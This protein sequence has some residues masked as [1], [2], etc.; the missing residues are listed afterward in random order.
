MQTV[1][2]GPNAR[3]EPDLAAEALIPE[4]R[5][6]Q[7]RRHRRELLI[8]LVLALAGLAFYGAFGRPSG[9]THVSDQTGGPSSAGLSQ[10]HVSHPAPEGVPFP[11]GQGFQIGAPDPEAAITRALGALSP[12]PYV[13]DR[14]DQIS[15][16]QSDLATALRIEPSLRQQI[17]Y[18]ALLPGTTR[19]W[20]VAASGRW[21]L[22]CTGCQASGYVPYPISSVSAGVLA[23]VPVGFDLTNVAGPP[24]TIQSLGL[25]GTPHVAPL[26]WDAY[27]ALPL[28]SDSCGPWSKPTQ[29]LPRA[30]TAKYGM[31]Q[32]C[33]LVGHTWVLTTL[34]TATHSGVVGLFSC[35]TALCEQSGPSL[36][37]RRWRFLNPPVDT[38]LRAIVANESPSLLVV[39]AEGIGRSFPSAYYSLD[40]KSDI[41]AGPV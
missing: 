14:V 19:I 6:R 11:G 36:E 28:G 35:S 29:A 10:T 27:E 32:D 15:Y 24:V 17:P 1:K 37:L 18:A 7:R 16:V 39:R 23:G 22:T 40:L 34:G 41:F 33:Q 13:R 38:E 4:A 25:F 12:P 30:I 31:L 9:P 20:L 3:I 5:A 21:E 8:A 2:A 26:S